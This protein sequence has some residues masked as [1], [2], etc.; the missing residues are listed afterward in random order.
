MS[1]TPSFS[2][3]ASASLRRSRFDAL[4]RHALLPPELG[5]FAA[6]AVGKADHRHR[7]AARAV[8]RDRAAG[9]PDEIGGMGADDERGLRFLGHIWL[10]E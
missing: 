8:Q 5:A 7:L 4:Q 10:L 1:A 6:L 9:A 2:A 3:A